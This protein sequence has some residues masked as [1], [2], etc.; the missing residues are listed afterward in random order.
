MVGGADLFGREFRMAAFVLDQWESGGEIA[1]FWGTED[2]VEEG[3]DVGT[4]LS[5]E[6][7]NNPF[8]VHNV[9]ANG[10]WVREGF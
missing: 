2:A 8:D 6:E 3:S 1:V 7:S 10:E 5:F 4:V 9:G